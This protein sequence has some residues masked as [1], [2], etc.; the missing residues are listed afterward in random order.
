MISFRDAENRLLRGTIAK[1]HSGR[2]WAGRRKVNS[3]VQDCD[4]IA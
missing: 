4:K 2:C 1:V 3:G